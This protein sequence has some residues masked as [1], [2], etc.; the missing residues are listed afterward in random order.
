MSLLVSFSAFHTIVTNFLSPISSY[1]P[2]GFTVVLEV[3]RL[4]DSKDYLLLEMCARVFGLGLVIDP[5]LTLTP[6]A[7]VCKELGL[8]WKFFSF[9]DFPR[10]RFES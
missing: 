3:T 6:M 5:C 4:D 10:S 7:L 1:L 9:T 2:G 8:N